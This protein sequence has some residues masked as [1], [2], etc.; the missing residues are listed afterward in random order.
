MLNLR[1]VDLNLLPVFEAAYEERNL[2]RAAERLAMTP[3]AVSHAVTRLRHVFNNE[4]FVPQA[5]GMLPTPGADR[6]YA[7]LR[8]ALTSVRESVAEARGFEPKTSARR[9]FISIPHPLGPKIAVRLRER[10]AHAAPGIEV[11]FSTRSRPVELERGMREGRV[12]AAVDWLVPTG[13]KFREVTL[14]ED[15]VVAVARHGHPALRRPASIKTLKE[16]AFVTLRPRSEGENPV[17]GLQEWSRLNLN[18]TLEV[19]EVLEVLMVAA[20]SDL[21]G[22]IPRSMLK[23]AH[24]LFGL[25]AL[26]AG[27]KAVSVP[28]KLVWHES[29]DADP[30]HAFLRKQIA[31][32]SKDI[33]PKGS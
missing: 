23:I 6:V 25:R 1:S 29:R 19:S 10:L 30:G 3:S 11:T 9:F 24:S 32:S 7:K 8:G 2:S 28:V 17:A 22:L 16:G 33:V 18:C 31:L 27:P 4:L 5:R 15:A 26:Q 13:P 14:F 21:F 20:E 12:D